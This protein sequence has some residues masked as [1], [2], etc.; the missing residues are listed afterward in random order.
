MG[1]GWIWFGII[2]SDGVFVSNVESAGSANAV[3]EHKYSENRFI[4]HF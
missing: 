3:F 1:N 4:Q 2:P